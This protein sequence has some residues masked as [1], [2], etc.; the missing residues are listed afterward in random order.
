MLAIAPRRKQTWFH[1]LYLVIQSLAVGVAVIGISTVWL[2]GYFH[3]PPEPVLAGGLCLALVIPA[4]SL[5]VLYRLVL[6][7]S[8][9][10]EAF[11]RKQRDASR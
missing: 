6:F 7:I 1:R 8:F 11:G 2:V 9:G 5:A 10:S 4:I 3:S